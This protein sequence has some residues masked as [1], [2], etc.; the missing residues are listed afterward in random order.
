MDTRTIEKVA[1]LASGE[2]RDSTDSSRKLSKILK[3][4]RRGK[5][6]NSNDDDEDPLSRSTTGDDA[7]PTSLY[8]STVA[9]EERVTEDSGNFTEDS[10][11]ES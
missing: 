11:S 5:K 10:E 8:S 7:G 9:S 4:K 1:T 6:G 2:R 3:G